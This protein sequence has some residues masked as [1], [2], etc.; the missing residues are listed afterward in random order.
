MDRFWGL[1]LL[2]NGASSGLDVVIFGGQRGDLPLA[3]THGAAIA[4]IVGT[5]STPVI[6]VTRLMTVADR[7]RFFT[8]FAETLVRKNTGPLHLLIDEAH[9]FMPQQGAKVSGGAPAMLH[10]GNNLVSLGRGIGLRIMLLSQRPA[11][12]HNDSLG[13]VET[14]IAFRLLLPHDRAAVRMWIR[15][16]ADEATG[17]E[18]LGSLPSLPTGTGWLWAPELDLLAKIKIPRIHTFDSGKAL[19][20]GTPAPVLRP[21]DLAAVS[22]QL[23]QVAEE[24]AA[25]DPRRLKV[26]I[27]DL[28]RQLAAA[29]E[30]AKINTTDPGELAIAEER[31]AARGRREVM[32]R[33]TGKLREDWL[34]AMG[35]TL[36]AAIVREIGRTFADTGELVRQL[37]GLVEPAPE[38][39]RGTPRYTAPAGFTLWD[40]RQAAKAVTLFKAALPLGLRTCLTAI[41]QHDGGVDRDQLSVL[42]GYKRSTR[43]A[44]LRKL[45]DR[46]DVAVAGTGRVIATQAGV[47]EL[48][49]DYQPL[50][51]GAGL[52]DY[53][54]NRLPEGER[55]VLEVLL[56]AYPNDLQRADIDV[57][58][59][60]KRSTRD[61]YLSKLITRRLIEFG[62]EGMRATS[63]LF[64]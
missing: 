53:W 50:P 47:A 19:P 1:R 11:K 61:A 29:N 42:T 25:N 14:L 35:R 10:A 57:A 23:A 59:G 3:A 32:A 41:A 39:P 43:D 27:A 6:L 63:R 54:M 31:G 34:P 40:G 55:R 5:T 44:Y 18:L 28:E 4:E 24:A 13:Q 36:T 33:V 30:G 21:L 7:T 46:G 17:A 12:L 49:D 56:Q 20:P 22:Q 51:T 2:A 8:D 45:L 64:D 9:L 62:T 26:R 37:G 16:W 38:V 48:G 58:T 60:Y 52:R 15:E